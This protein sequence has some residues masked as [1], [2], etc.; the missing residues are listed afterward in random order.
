MAT[1][2]LRYG[3]RIFKT[4][5]WCKAEFYRKPHR[6]EAGRFCSREC[7]FASLRKVKEDR[8]ARLIVAKAQQA[9]PKAIAHQ[10]LHCGI[11]FQSVSP[12]SVYCSR[13]CRGK[14]RTYRSQ[15]QPGAKEAYRSYMRE[16][17]RHRA[18]LVE[19]Q[20]E[21]RECGSLFETARTTAYCCSMRCSQKF[22]RRCRDY[23]KRTTALP[24]E[25]L[26]PVAVFE[27]DKWTCQECGVSTPSARRGT[28]ALDAPELDHIMPLSRGGT[29]TYSNVQCLCRRCNMRKGARIPAAA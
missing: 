18:G 27:R 7:S 1:P 17:M 3:E 15:Q 10:C 6:M 23:A 13:S 12:D 24:F 2:D 4:C 20:M 8:A 9:K 19:R 14:A 21:C 22:N 28:T 16:Y 11:G 5:E 25:R 26:S 29:H